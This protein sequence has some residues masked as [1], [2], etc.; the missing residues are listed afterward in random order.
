MPFFFLNSFLHLSYSQQEISYLNP[1]YAFKISKMSF[2]NP[3]IDPLAS[4]L[5]KIVAQECCTFLWV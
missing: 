4:P 5:L 3:Q 1:K 2:P